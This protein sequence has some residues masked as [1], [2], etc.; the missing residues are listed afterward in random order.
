MLRRTRNDRR[1][2]VRL[3]SSR[4][5]VQRNHTLRHALRIPALRRPQH[6]QTLQ[7][8]ISRRIRTA[9]IHFTRLQRHTQ[10]HTQCQ[11]RKQIHHPTNQIH[12]VVST[13]RLPVRTERHTYRQKPHRSKL[14]SPPSHAGQRHR[15]LSSEKLCHQQ[16]AQQPHRLLL[17]PQKEIIKLAQLSQTH[18]PAQPTA[19]P[20]QRQSP[21]L[22]T[23]SQTQPN[24]S[25]KPRQ[26]P[27]E[28]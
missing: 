27:K 14:N 24:S 25:P 1:Q 17:S 9:Q 21:H 10:M 22:P 19:T 26:K 13:T 16:P 4:R 3:P 28:R 5:V 2:K 12:R 8:N 6:Q 7:K 15:P 11:P 23:L 18:Q 20:P